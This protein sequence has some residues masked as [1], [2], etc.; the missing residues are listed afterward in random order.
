MTELKYPQISS[1]AMMIY[2]NTLMAISHPVWNKY[3]VLLKS[4]S[5]TTWFLIKKS[6]KLHLNLEF[7]SLSNVPLEPAHFGLQ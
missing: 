4:F 6:D 5:F 2:K 7:H 3:C 1:A